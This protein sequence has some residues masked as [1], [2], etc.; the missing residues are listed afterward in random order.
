MNVVDLDGN[1]ISWNLTGHISKGRVQEKSSYHLAARKLLIETYPTLH[2]LEEVSIPLRKS[3]VLYLDFF[4]PLTKTVVE[5]H[6]QQHYE[7]IPFYH[8]SKM[9][10][11][12]AQAKDKQK[13]EWCLING[14][15]FIVFPYNN[16]TE[17]W[18]EI[19]N[20]YK[21]I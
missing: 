8:A 15:K 4:M 10:F 20:E 3:E 17:E 21:N 18:K 13:E 11:L 1:R 2:I 14:L 12:K 6:G 7:F 5:V 16:T 19:L 9:A